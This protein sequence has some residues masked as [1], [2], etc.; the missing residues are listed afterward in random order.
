MEYARARDPVGSVGH[1][2]LG[3]TYLRAGRWDDAITSYRTSLRLSP[4]RLNAHFFIGV[5]LLLK[6][7]PQA[8]LEAIVQEPRAA[9]RLRGLAL[10]HHALGDRAASDAA[11]DTLIR[12]RGE[13]DPYAVATALAYRGE[14]DRAFQWLARSVEA[15]AGGRLGTH[16]DPLL[17]NLHADPRW[18]PFL[19]SIGQA[20][21]QLD[22]IQFRAAT[23]AGVG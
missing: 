1:S 18:L 6:E 9:A 8:A 12:S 22:A 7:E 17:A 21:H 2:N 16:V 14:V 10:A 4:G 20:R 15:E 13:E 23:L 3:H 11:M 5:A 19:E